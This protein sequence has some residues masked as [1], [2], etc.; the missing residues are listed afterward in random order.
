MSS[1]LSNFVFLGL[2]GYAAYKYW[3]RKKACT[4]A[5]IA[6]PAPPVSQPDATELKLRGDSFSQATTPPERN[7]EYD[8]NAINRRS[9]F[10]ADPNQFEGVPRKK[11][12]AGF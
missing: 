9:D 12:R 11:K 5:L 8:D 10:T 1:E 3:L 6:P 4:E 7:Y 2:T